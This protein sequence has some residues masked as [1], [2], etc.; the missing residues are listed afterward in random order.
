MRIH[1]KMI[2]AL[3]ALVGAMMLGALV[4]PRAAI[5]ADPAPGATALPSG[6]AERLRAAE[7][8]HLH[9]GDSHE[10]FSRYFRAALKEDRYGGRLMGYDRVW[11]TDRKRTRLHSSH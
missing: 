5:A 6:L 11:R 7:L 4:S 1:E 3:P 8:H 9:I 2:R 10:T